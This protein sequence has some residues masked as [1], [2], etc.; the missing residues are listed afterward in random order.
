MFRSPTLRL[1]AFLLAILAGSAPAH[2]EAALNA[3]EMA[4]FEKM[5]GASGQQRPSLKIDPVLSQV[6]RARAADMARRDY[7]AHDNPDGQSPNYL[8]RKAGYE[9][10]ASYPSNGNN[11]ES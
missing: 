9:L 7:F 11:V 10:P 8:V 4:V 6:A 1:L 2:L 3:Q 5:Q